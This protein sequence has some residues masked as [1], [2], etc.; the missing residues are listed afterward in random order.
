MGSSKHAKKKTSK[1]RLSARKA[2]EDWRARM[3]NAV[4]VG[5]IE[6]SLSLSD[7]RRAEKKKILRDIKKH[8]KRYND[9]RDNYTKDERAEDQKEH[10]RMRVS[11]RLRTGDADSVA[12]FLDVLRATGIAT[13][14]KVS[15]NQGWVY[16][17]RLDGRTFK[18]VYDPETETYR[19]L[20]EE[21]VADGEEET[22][23]KHSS[24][25]KTN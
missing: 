2:M 4:K 20:W 5:I 11:Q 23:N 7:I 22:N 6:P 17:F 25:G 3:K 16:I 18:F 21:G 1:K 8:R 19:T 10:F 12:D 15:I 13:F 9:Y 14:Q 24:L